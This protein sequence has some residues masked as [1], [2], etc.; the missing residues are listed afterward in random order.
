MAIG[1]HLIII[2]ILINAN[3]IASFIAINFIISIAKRTGFV[4][5]PNPIVKS[6][7]QPI[8]L[9]GG[10]AF[11]IILL[12]SLILF[13]WVNELSVH[14]LVIILFTCLFGS[15]DD[16]IKFQPWTKFVGQNIVVLIYLFFASPPIWMFPIVWIL[17]VAC[18][19]A[20]NFIDV[21]DGLTGWVTV[22]A[23]SGI[24]G[25]TLLIGP[26]F[27][28]TVLCSAACIGVIGGFLFWNNFPAR[29]FMGEAGSMTLG[30]LFGIIVLDIGIIEPE[31]GSIIILTG[32]IPLFELGFLILE[33]LRKRIPIYKG[34][35]DHFALR[36]QCAGWTIPKILRAVILINALLVCAAF[37]LVLLS[38]NW[39]LTT[40]LLIILIFVTFMI[41]KYLRVLPTCGGYGAVKS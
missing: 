16:L 40:I 37:I 22:I 23:F 19:N 34:S 5:N 12:V 20:W 4:V 11:S 35:P 32:A 9:G 41:Y 24:L 27:N 13:Y 3:L 6:H 25:I 38:F 21:M 28:N 2:A 7:T 17:L 1:L 15:L 36:L 31:I 10:I 18:Q 14:Y 30:A 26:A 29:I 8:P 39:I 33:R